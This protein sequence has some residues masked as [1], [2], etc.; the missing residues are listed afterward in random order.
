MGTDNAPPRVGTPTSLPP[1]LMMKGCVYPRPT[2]Q[3]YTSV[4]E[5]RKKYTICLWIQLLILLQ[6]ANKKTTGI[7]MS[8]TF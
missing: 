3:A 7:F 5:H 1:S 6:D 4:P 8:F 2:Q